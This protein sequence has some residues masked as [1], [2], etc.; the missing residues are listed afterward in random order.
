M[1]AT[2]Y[3]TFFECPRCGSRYWG[4]VQLQRGN[5]AAAEGRCHDEFGKGCRFTW[6]REKEDAQVFKKRPFPAYRPAK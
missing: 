4:T 2:K 6:N 1:S 3:E 5:P